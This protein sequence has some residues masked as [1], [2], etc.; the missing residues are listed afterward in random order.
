MGGPGSGAKRKPGSP[1]RGWRD[2]YQLQRWRNIAKTQLAAEP[3][4][5]ECLKH[6]IVTPATVVDH[7]K[8]HEGDWNSFILGARQS[9]CGPCHARKHGHFGRAY[10]TDLDADGWPT[11]PKHPANRRR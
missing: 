7:I 8:E 9:L 5:A 4:C 2:W 1:D 11:D 3:L 10:R 6:D